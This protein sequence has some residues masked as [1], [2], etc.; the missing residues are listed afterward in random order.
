MGCKII[1]QKVQV[2]ALDDLVLNFSVTVK[3][4]VPLL[5]MCLQPYPFPLWLWLA[6]GW[7]LIH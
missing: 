2:I 5:L 4:T 1:N 3:V 7:C 6:S